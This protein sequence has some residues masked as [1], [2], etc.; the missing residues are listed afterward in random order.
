MVNYAGVPALRPLALVVPVLAVVV[1]A[2][3]VAAPLM[4][5]LPGM[6]CLLLNPQIVLHVPDAG[7]LLR[8]VL[9]PPLGL[10]AVDGAGQRHL[11]GRHAHLDLG[12]IDEGIVAQPI[13]HILA[14]AVVRAGIAFRATAPMLPPRCSSMRRRRSASSSPNHDETSSPARS[15]KP[16]SP[17]WP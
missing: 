7:D 4:P 8:D 16:R 11:A 2:A 9:G 1:S 10:T 3:P 15:Q 17:R 6:P 5:V 14:D 12:G 13:V